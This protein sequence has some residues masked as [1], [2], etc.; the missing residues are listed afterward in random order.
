[1]KTSFV[2]IQSVY[3]LKDKDDFI[4]E[5]SEIPDIEEL[6]IEDALESKVYEYSK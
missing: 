4:E 1:M 2:K 3:E 6:D 5:L